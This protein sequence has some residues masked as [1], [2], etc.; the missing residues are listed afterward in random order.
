MFTLSTFMTAEKKDVPYTV[1]VESQVANII[2]KLADEDE[3]TISFVLRKLIVEALEARK[4]IKPK[5]K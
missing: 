5:K 1:R 4:L 2:Q 3:R